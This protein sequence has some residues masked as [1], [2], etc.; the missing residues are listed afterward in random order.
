MRQE[1]CLRPQMYKIMTTLF[2]L[3]LGAAIGTTAF[4]EEYIENNLTEISY[5]SKFALSQPHS[6]Y[7]VFVHGLVGRWRF[8]MRTCENT[9]AFFVPLEK[10][11][12]QQF[13]T[14]LTGCEPCSQEER[15]LLALPAHLGGLNIA[16]P[17]AIAD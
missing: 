1:S 16:I 2:Q 12:H 5:L 11:I 10:A 7:A 13:I 6:V 17:T 9:S 3:H 8:V 4:A 14:A 15:Q